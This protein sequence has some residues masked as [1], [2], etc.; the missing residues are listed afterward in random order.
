[1][2]SPVSS[3]P[4]GLNPLMAGLDAIHLGRLGLGI[5]FPCY[6]HLIKI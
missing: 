1:M 3:I 2:T 6:G 4:L 5:I